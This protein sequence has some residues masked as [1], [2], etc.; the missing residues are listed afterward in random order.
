[1]SV[2]RAIDTGEAAALR[3]ALAA[4]PGLAN[5]LVLWGIRG[6]LRTHPLHYV[7]DRCFDGSLAKEAA[8][9]L[10]EVLLA[11][12]ADCNGSAENNETPL[13]GAASLGVEDVGLRLVEAGA[14]TDRIG[15]TGETALHWA[16]YLGL[17]QLVE[18]LLAAGAR[19][20][21]ADTRFKATALGWARHA[22]ANRP[23]GSSSG[24]ERVIQL[25]GG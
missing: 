25:L 15:S 14:D 8:L 24:H 22:M 7:C 4:S 10:V 1:M 16:A 19:T 11:A 23:L 17:A 9:P 5:E 12:G 21:V 20:D 3:E 13:H 6:H 18:K 2:K